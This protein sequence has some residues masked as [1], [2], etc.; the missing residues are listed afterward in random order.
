MTPGEYRRSLSRV[1]S[2]RRPAHRDR[3]AHRGHDLR[4]VRQPHRAVP[5]QDARASSTRPV[6]L[7][8]ERAT[9]RFDPAV[10]GRDELVQAVEAA[11]YEVRPETAPALAGA[12]APA[13]ADELTADDVERERAQ[14]ATLH[15]G[16]RRDRRRRSRSWS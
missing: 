8:T 4:L 15:P 14:R 13:L 1:S 16:G 7:A 2:R 11:G 6:N 3:P 5:A 9:V 10:A 12:A